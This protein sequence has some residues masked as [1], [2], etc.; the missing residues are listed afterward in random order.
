[1][2]LVSKI[3]I[4]MTIIVIISVILICIVLTYYTKIKNNLANLISS[5]QDKKDK[6]Q[7]TQTTP[8]VT[9]IKIS[10]M[11]NADNVITYTNYIMYILCGIVILCILCLLSIFIYLGYKVFWKPKPIY[12]TPPRMTTPM[13]PRIEY[14][15]PMPIKKRRGPVTHYTVRESP[16]DEDE[17]DYLGTTPQQRRRHLPRNLFQNPR[18]V[19]FT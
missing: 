10:D 17:D 19:T 16:G 1:M 15:T 7:T 2:E 12:Y 3:A 9:L 13:P 5:L 8:C 4:L 11:E 14:R 18:S 6:C